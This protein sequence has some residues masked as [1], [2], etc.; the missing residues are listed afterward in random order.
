MLLQLALPA[1]DGPLGE[2]QP[3]TAPWDEGEV[4]LVTTELATGD[5]EEPKADE[6]A[7]T[8]PAGTKAK[9]LVIE[10]KKKGL[11]VKIA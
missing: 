11:S 2:P 3:L 9:H 7:G 10:I 8:E 4:L 1:Q 5:E 6:A